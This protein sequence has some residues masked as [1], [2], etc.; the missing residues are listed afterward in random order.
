MKE[1]YSDSIH[2]CQAVQLAAMDVLG[3]LTSNPDLV[4]VPA[5]KELAERMYMAAR[6]A[7][8]VARLLDDHQTAKFTDNI[9]EK[10]IRIM[11]D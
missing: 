9:A 1:K 4:N 7:A 3:D 6:Q 8:H 11:E 5:Y 2:T 10:I